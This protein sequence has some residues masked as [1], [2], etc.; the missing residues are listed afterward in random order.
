MALLSELWHFDRTKSP[1]LFYG[2]LKDLNTFYNENNASPE[3]LK[4]IQIQEL[5]TAYANKG[6]AYAALNNFLQTMLGSTQGTE[7][8][9]FAKLVQGIN[10]GL[11]G[12]KSKENR[13]VGWTK[14]SYYDKLDN[15]VKQIEQLA[16]QAAGT[17]GIPAPS[18]DAVKHAVGYY[19]FNGFIQAKGQYLEDLG[20]WIMEMAGLTGFSTGSWQAVDKFFG[21]KAQ[22][23]IIEDAMGLL[24]DGTQHLKGGSSNFLSVQIQNYNKLNTAGKRQA[25]A[26]LQQWVNSISE[27]N[28]AQVLNGRVKIG[29]DISTPEQF[30]SAISLINNNASSAK[31]N[32]SISLSDNLYQQI[33][34]L[35]VN[36]QGK[37]NIE[38]HL[39]NKGNRSLY[40]ID[41]SDKYYSQLSL[42]SHMAPVTQ[43]TAVT[44]EEQNTPYKEFAAYVNYN[45]SKNINNTVY[46]RN[47]YYLTVEGFTDLAT[48]MEKRNFYIRIKDSFLSYKQFLNNS[49]RTIYD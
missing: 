21:E 15:I 24:M 38:R 48:L 20:A 2:G 8:D 41:P 31:A 45:L 28:G 5:K 22:S 34:K 29:S 35:S 4:A 19:D 32:L 16:N 26:E 49:F 37:S 36:I 18:I 30:A 12:F 14:A 17:E 44:A 25:D 7:E 9:L 42:F 27:L 1:M 39:A 47:E 3:I 46:G 40:S 43:E 6:G 13:D 10:E 11:N 33:Q 23:S